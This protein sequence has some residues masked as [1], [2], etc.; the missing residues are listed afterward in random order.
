MLPTCCFVLPGLFNSGPRHWQSRWEELYGYTRIHQR[1]WETP[2]AADWLHT[3]DEVLAPFPPEN[4]ILIGHSLACCTIVRWAEHYQRTIKA[5]LL[6][7]PADTEAPSYP[8][9]TTGFQPM[10]L[11][12]LP[13]PSIVVASTDDFYVSS[14]RAAFFAASWGSRLVSIGAHGHINSD[15]GLNDW[16]QGHQLLQTLF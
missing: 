1:D 7:A 3:I 15:S 2:D 10:P 9:G 11:Y 4:V 12:T 5:A 16:P 14:K 6:V 8:S 13:F